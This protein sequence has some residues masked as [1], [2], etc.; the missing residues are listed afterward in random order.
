DGLALSASG[1]LAGIP[2]IAGSIAFS[3]I[4][5]SGTLSSEDRLV[6]RVVPLTSSPP[7]T[8]RIRWMKN[9]NPIPTRLRACRVSKPRCR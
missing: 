6:I 1:R 3:V 9:A 5:K 7:I 8:P 2:T 4:V